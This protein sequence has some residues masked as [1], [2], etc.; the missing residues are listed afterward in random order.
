VH[1]PSLGRLLVVLV[2]GVVVPLFGLLPFLSVVLYAT[3][4]TVG[5][6]SVPLPARLMIHTKL[7]PLQS[8]PFLF[9]G[10]AQKKNC[11]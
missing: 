7:M 1:D 10:G 3:L 9:R 11:G 4:F 5:A 2:V 6:A 8:H